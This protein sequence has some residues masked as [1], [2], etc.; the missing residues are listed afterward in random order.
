M[1]RMGSAAKAQFGRDKVTYQPEW[2]ERLDRICKLTLRTSVI[3][4]LFGLDPET[5]RDRLKEAIDRRY[6]RMGADMPQR[7]R[8]QA[9][10]YQFSTFLDSMAER[11]DAAY[12]LALHYPHGPGEF[13]ETEFNLGR[14]VDKLMDTFEQY[15][16]NLYP[17]VG[18]FNTRVSFDEFCELVKGVRA[19]GIEMHTCRD[20]GSKYPVSVVR[21]GTSYCPVC[22]FH[23]PK[24]ALLRREFENRRKALNSSV[25]AEGLRIAHA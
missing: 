4:E 3:L 22:H 23:K 18:A 8:G 14:A 17:S 11:Y 20:C 6:L 13:A 7:P 5:D 1:N 15:R 9:A 12:L 24:F 2:E 10:S 16:V 21:L 19:S 25:H